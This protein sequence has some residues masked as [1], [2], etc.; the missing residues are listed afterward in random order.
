MG[1]A[2]SI[3]HW[4]KLLRIGS[5]YIYIKKVVLMKKCEVISVNFGKFRGCKEYVAPV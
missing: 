5:N 2:T 3:S 1:K 4:L